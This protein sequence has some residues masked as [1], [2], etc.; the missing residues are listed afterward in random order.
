[1]ATSDKS[2]CPPEGWNRYDHAL[3]TLWKRRY[4]DE[5]G[6]GAAAHFAAGLFDRDHRRPIAQWTNPVLDAALLVAAETAPEWPI[7]RFA[8]FYAPPGVGVVKLQSQAHEWR[9]RAPRGC[10]TEEDA[11]IA[12]VR[13]AHEFLELEARFI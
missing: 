11:F 6:A 4:E 3:L 13:Q 9:P 5:F 8:I 10:P 7:Q 2:G 1:M 12:A